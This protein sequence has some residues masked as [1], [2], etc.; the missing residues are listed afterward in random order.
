M[1]CL[2]AA[3]QQLQHD[4]QGCEP[5]MQ[6]YI[7][8]QIRWSPCVRAMVGPTDAILILERTAR[9]HG[10]HSLWL[11]NLVCKPV[12]LVGMLPVASRRTTCQSIVRLK[13]CTRLPTVR[14]Y[15][16]FAR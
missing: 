16:G 12:A 7:E 6:T 9:T 15:G 4:A 3:F 13:P 2:R 10:E 11:T 5:I 14:L 1:L 8:I